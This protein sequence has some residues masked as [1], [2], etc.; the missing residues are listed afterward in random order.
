MSN[1][2]VRA[3]TIPNPKTCVSFVFNGRPVEVEGANPLMTLNEWI[4]AQPGQTGTKVMCAEG[5][6]GCCVVAA[7][8]TDPTTLKEKTIAIN[9]VRPSKA[10]NS[11]LVSSPVDA[12]E[13]N[14]ACG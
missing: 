6:C 7:A 2:T 4:R 1:L 3:E 5:G 10:N 13:T 9:S 8:L 11:Y 14:E 12:R